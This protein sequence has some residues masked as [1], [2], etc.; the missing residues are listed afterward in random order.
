MENMEQVETLN[1][2]NTTEES[3]KIE[4][5]TNTSST[6]R[7]FTVDEVNEIV[8]K[9][10][11]KQK[12]NF[13][14]NNPG[15]N[16]ET[17][18]EEMSKIHDLEVREKNLHLR[19]MKADVKDKLKGDGLPSDLVDYIDYSNDE[20][21]EKSYNNLKGIFE[22]YKASIPK[23]PFSTGMAH[24]SATSKEHDPIAEAFKPRK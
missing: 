17:S 15:S 14:K 12:K 11:A 19:E 16:E 7:T 21:I 10:L 13:E 4:Q 22:K 3:K 8:Q 9:R 20:S 18:Q 24:S 2:Q 1:T 5:N 6:D 23:T